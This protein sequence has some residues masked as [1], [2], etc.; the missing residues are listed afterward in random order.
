MIITLNFSDFTTERNFLNLQNKFSSYDERYF[1]SDIDRFSKVVREDFFIIYKMI[2]D[3]HKEIYVELSFINDFLKPKI[4]ELSA[5]IINK[6]T[7]R[8]RNDFLYNEQERNSFLKITLNDFFKIEQN[9]IEANYLELSI[10]NQLKHELDIV[11]DF[12]STFNF[13]SNFNITEKIQFNLNKT[14]LLVLMHLLRDKQ[15]INFKTDS[16]LGNLI[17]NNFQCQDTA[18]KTYKDITRARKEINSLKNTNK[19]FIKSINRLKE[20]FQNDSFYVS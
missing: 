17:E 13:S 14:D 8:L 10:I 9:I 11:I 2:D 16:E 7:N 1:G 12:I 20:I 3:T 15:I 19:T 4:S 6:I 5:S 18:S